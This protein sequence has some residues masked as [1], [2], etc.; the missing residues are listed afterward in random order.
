MNELNMSQFNVIHRGII[1]RAVS[2]RMEFDENTQ[3]SANGVSPKF[4]DV[5][6][7]NEDN[8]LIVLGGCRRKGCA[9]S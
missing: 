9:E 6:A 7:L 5:V 3:A 2:V 1:Y 8:N 4:L